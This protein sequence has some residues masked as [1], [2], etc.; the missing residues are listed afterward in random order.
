MKHAAI[1]I[2]LL[3]PQ[4]DL[5]AKFEAKRAT[6]PLAAFKLLADAG[7]EPAAKLA[8][9]ALAQQISADTAAG[10]KAWAE[11]KGDV[12]DVHLVR[13]ALLAT[14][15]APD[16]SRQILRTL[17]LLKA[18]RKTVT[19]CGGCKGAGSAPCAGCK[20]GLVLGPCPHCEAKG[21]V[22]CV[23]CD[24]SGTLDHHGYKGTLLLTIERETPFKIKDA[25]GKPVSGKLPAQSLTYTMASCAG[26]SFNLGTRSV[27]T[28]TNAEKTGS[29]NQTCEAFWKE[30]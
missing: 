9:P 21:T 2:L 29:A 16:F 17:S 11:A 14:P 19:G 27:V 15:Y 30:M 28:K 10:L 12:A 5:K 6:D 3:L 24:G 25:K 23:L 8:R 26:G 7:G 4:D 18:P 1:A 13:A 20:E 22:A